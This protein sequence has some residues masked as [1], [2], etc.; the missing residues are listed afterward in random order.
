METH[1]FLKFYQTHLFLL[2]ISNKCTKLQIV[3]NWRME[4]KF[5]TQENVK[6]S[7]NLSD[8]LSQLISSSL[9]P[10]VSFVH[11]CPFLLELCHGQGGYNFTGYMFIFKCFSLINVNASIHLA[12]VPVELLATVSSSALDSGSHEVKPSLSNIFLSRI[13]FLLSLAS[14]HIHS[15]YYKVLVAFFLF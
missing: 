1:F 12:S 3:I 6:W 8:L 10:T 14:P 5:K 13:A 7:W 15:S 11:S 9:A 2:V 4:V